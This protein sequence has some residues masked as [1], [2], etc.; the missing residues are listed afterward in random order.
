MQ[1]KDYFN[2]VTGTGVL[3]TADANGVVNVAIYAKPHVTDNGRLAFL[4]RERSTYRNIGENPSAS[5]LFME[6]GISYTGVRIQLL[7]QDEEEDEE[8]IEQMTRDWISLGADLSLGP[9][10]LVFFRIEKI[11]SLVGDGVPDL[12][13]DLQ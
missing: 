8:L 10:H 9:K 4:M 7:K 13:W 11:R 12:T 2:Q 6:A 5:Y 3:C 1:L